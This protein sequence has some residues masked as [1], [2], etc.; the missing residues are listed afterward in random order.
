MSNTVKGFQ[1]Y[2]L[3]ES[4][5]CNLTSFFLTWSNPERKGIYQIILS[6]SIF[7]SYDCPAG[8]FCTTLKI[9]AKFSTYGVQIFHCQLFDHYQFPRPNDDTCIHQLCDFSNWADWQGNGRKLKRQL[10]LQ[11][12]QDISKLLWFFLFQIQIHGSLISFQLCML[13]KMSH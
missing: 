9:I 10:I 1:F 2:I 3:V 6:D 4:S 12:F 11:S 5:V 8:F 13:L 7:N